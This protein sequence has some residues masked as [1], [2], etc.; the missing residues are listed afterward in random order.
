MERCGWCLDGGI[1]QKYHD[2]EW[3]EPLH[4]DQKHFEYLL[5]E[6]MQCGLNWNMMLK[7]RDVFRKC[8]D[9]FDYRLVADYTDADVERIMNTEGMIRSPRKI[10]AIINN[11]NCF[12]KVIEEVGSFDKYIWSFSDDHTLI[13]RKH[14][15]G[16]GEVRNELSDRL[17]RDMKKRGF[18]YLGSITI[19]S[20]L[21]A[22]GIIN[23]H[24][25]KCFKYEKLLKKSKVKYIY[26]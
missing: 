13:Y 16:Q 14:Q 10:S 21:Q 5:M 17:S 23:D 1:L 19:F 8:F 18:K 12:L 3:G 2:E 4:D 6:A 15:Q 7:K 20:H 24:S 22:C 25:C 9:G 11:A 26:E